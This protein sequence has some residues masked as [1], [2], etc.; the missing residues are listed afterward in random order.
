[1]IFFS[2]FFLLLPYGRKFLCLYHGANV[3]YELFTISIYP[4]PVN[5]KMVGYHLFYDAKVNSR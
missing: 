4:Y 1:M 3:S 2:T 5:M